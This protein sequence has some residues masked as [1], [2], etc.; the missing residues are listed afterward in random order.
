MPPA[1]RCCISP[2]AK[3]PHGR[4][5]KPPEK[6]GKRKAAD[7]FWDFALREPAAKDCFLFA[8]RAENRSF[9]MPAMFRAR[10]FDGEAGGLLTELAGEIVG[11][12]LSTRLHDYASGLA[13]AAH[14]QRLPDSA[15]A[16]WLAR[17]ATSRCRRSTSAAFAPRSPIRRCCGNS[18]SASASG[19]SPPSHT[20]PPGTCSVTASRAPPGRKTRGPRRPAFPSRKHRRWR[21]RCAPSGSAL[22]P[23]RRRTR[24]IRLRSRTPTNSGRTSKPSARAPRSATALLRRSPSRCSIGSR[25]R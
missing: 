12:E 3:R 11:S 4:L 16:A 8:A 15:Q 7:R 5:A 9:A 21:S 25:P 1:R 14:G 23:R 10:A 18:P 24:S 2:G 19:R 13:P 6:R 22:P 20:P 17:C